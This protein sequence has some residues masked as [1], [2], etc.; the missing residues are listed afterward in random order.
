MKIKNDSLRISASDLSNYL[1]CRRLTE[2]DLLL[3]NKKIQEPVFNNP[4]ADAVQ[5]RGFEHE[6]SYV[7]YLISQG[8][9]VKRL[10]SDTSDYQ[11][12]LDKTLIAMKEGHDVLVQATLK[13]DNYFGRADILRKVPRPSKLG[14]Y[15]YEI[16]DTKLSRETKASSVLQLCLYSEMLTQMQG[17]APENLYIVTPASNFVP[18]VYRLDDYN[19]YYR[20][21]KYNLLKAINEFDATQTKHYPE[22]R[23]HCDVCRWFE[24]CNEKR[25]IDDHLSFVA[26]LSASQRKELTELGIFTLE[27]FATTSSELP[28][29]SLCNSKEQ[30]R[31]QLDARK[32]GKPK[33]ELLPVEEGRGLTRLPEPSPGDIFFDLEGDVF[34]GTSGIEYLWGYSYLNELGQIEYASKWSLNYTEEK[35][36]FERFIDFV[37][38]QKVKFPSMKIYHYAPYEPS[39]LKRLMG[40]YG[41]R[42]AELDQMLREERFVDLYSITRQSIRAGIEKY[43]IKDLEQFYNFM[44]SAKL[45]DVG[46]HK[47]LVEHLLE[48]GS[49]NIPDDSKNVVLEYNKDDCIS[50][51]KLRD[52]L[53]DLRQQAIDAGFDVLRPA[54]VSGIVTEELSEAI[55]KMNELRDSLQKG[56]NPVPDER[57]STEQG[58]WLLSE[59]IQFYRREDKSNFFE[60]FRLRELDALELC[61]DKSGIGGLK[62]LGTIEGGTAKCPFERFS[63]LP[64]EIDIKPG[65]DL[66]IEGGHG[67]R[68]EFKVGTLLNINFDNLSLE[69]KKTQAGK[70]VIPH[71]LWSW[72]HI[73][74]TGKADKIIELAQYV[75]DNGIDNNTNTYKAAREILLRKNP[76][77]KNMVTE[78]NSLLRAKTMAL[79]L[80]HSYLAIQGPPGTGKSFT[81]SRVITALLEKGYKIGV[82][83]LSHKVISNLLA[84]VHEAG[85][86]EKIKTTIYQKTEDTSHPSINYLKNNGQVSS[87]LNKQEPLV[88]GATDFTWA[89]MPNEC[90][91]YLIIDEAGQYSLAGLL[92]IAH[93][94]KNIILLGDGAQLTQ[95]LKGSHPDGCEISALDFIV[96]EAKTLP[97]EK[98]VFLGVTYRLNDKIC[99]FNSELFYENRLRAVDGNEAQVISGVT[100]YAGKALVLEQIVHKGN[101]NKCKEEI[102]KIKEIVTDLL[103]QGNT[104][105]VIHDGK[106]VTHQISENTIKI[107]TPYNAQVN[108]LSREFPNIQIGTVDKFQG[109]ESPIV[110]YSVCTSSAEDAPRGMDFLYSGNRLNVAVSRAQCL[111]IMVASPDI[112]EVDCKNQAQMKL[113]NA[114]AKFKELSFIP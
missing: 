62:S 36:A 89:G 20:L 61:E 52:W 64:Q 23:Q 106:V 49:S 18:E 101:S 91:D 15:S 46:P 93:C 56:I 44:R 108:L 28:S 97:D 22:P 81:A 24:V 7:D 19:A 82:T 104:Y 67:D 1:S 70:D 87:L 37:I 57:S 83:A 78:T 112:F 32:S 59:L 30:A 26:G 110:I 34:F 80:N 100:K 40:R 58:Q 53:E 3:V 77:L 51:L 71:A 98:G 111:F 17:L 85:E 79:N 42:E 65:A 114:Y 8:L 69:I 9:T 105:S 16:V 63:F 43:S 109:Q 29:E 92:A 103:K 35:T 13:L 95:P 50:A 72:S 10:D 73:D 55:R 90:V 4:H 48:L 6:Q 96:G 41:V 2:L 107:I 102:V 113:A 31:L 75:L 68:D 39:A 94:T 11:T 5:K 33:Y 99:E 74:T 27:D 76:D 66:F 86:K 84:K 47:R 25:R 45:K 88:L 21:I 12:G 60:K 54:E 14:E 38:Q